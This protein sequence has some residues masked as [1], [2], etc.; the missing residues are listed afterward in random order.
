M[1]KVTRYGLQVASYKLRVTSYSHRKPLTSNLKPFT[2]HLTPLTSYLI[3]LFAF[4]FFSVFSSYGQ[5]TTKEVPYSWDK[6]RGEVTIE[7]I[8]I[9]TMPHLDMGKL[10]K[11]D[12]L[13]DGNGTPFRFGYS[14]KVN[15]T[16]SNSGSWTTTSDGG[17][18][19]TLRIYSPD[20]LSLNL[21]YDSFWLPDGAKFFIYSEDK[22]QHIGAFTANNNRGAKEDNTGF[23]TAFLFT[24][25]M[26]LE[27]YEPADTYNTGV[28][29]ICN[30][31]SG[32]RYAFDYFRSNGRDLPPDD[33]SCFRSIVC[34]PEFYEVKDAV[35]LMTMG[36]HACSGALLNNTANDNSPLFLSANHCFFDSV[37]TSNWIFYW[38]F[39][40]LDCS[41]I[42]ASMMKSTTGANLLA[43]RQETDFMLLK[44]TDDPGLYE[45]ITVYYLGW[46][47]SDVSAPA[48][49]CIH[50]PLGLPKMISYANKYIEIEPNEI[51]WR[52][53]YGNIIEISEPNTHWNVGFTRYAVFPGSS[54]SPI[55]NLDKRVMGQLHGG[56]AGCPPQTIQTNFFGRFDVSWDGNSSSERLKD[57]LDPNNSDP[58]YIDG[59]DYQCIHEISLTGVVSGT[60][61]YQGVNSITSTQEIEGGTTS[62]KAVASITLLPGFHAKSGSDFTAYLGPCEIS[63]SILSVPEMEDQNML[64]N[65]NLQTLTQ[66]LSQPQVNLHPNPNTG[67]FQLETNFLLSDISHLK[68]MDMLGVTVYETKNITSNLISLEN[69]VAGFYCVV[70]ILKDGTVLTEK[71]MIRR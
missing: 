69:S 54:G 31:I 7:S 17:Q 24:N 48:G 63:R 14:E 29:S 4:C 38:N 58:P 3:P 49:R 20:A 10:Q 40:H 62:Y 42:V 18:L 6:G 19:W 33:P 2:S 25:S 50:H 5:K 35:A 60:N 13:N 15:L 36:G 34:D 47:R 55:L 1:K 51:N 71:M 26:V 28:I 52:D 46:D 66:S 23:A 44:L 12:L 53:K 61:H 68:V 39:E 41:D 9:V 27:Y 37:S 57:W 70:I 8:P 45:D 16:M 67:T 21:L 22:K 32:Y 43:K 30:V 65:S 11:E 64:E 59:I 56:M